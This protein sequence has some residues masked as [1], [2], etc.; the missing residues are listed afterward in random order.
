MPP[1]IVLAHIRQRANVAA[2]H[3]GHADLAAVPYQVDVKG[4]ISFRGNELT[5]NLVSFFVCGVFRYPA[6]SLGHAKNMGIDRKRG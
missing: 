2:R 6:E 1:P 3:A 5:K 4:I